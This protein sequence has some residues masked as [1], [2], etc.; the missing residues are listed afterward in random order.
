MTD[1]LMA[2]DEVVAAYYDER[3]RRYGDDVR[4]LDWGSRESQRLRFSV[5]SGVGP[6]AGSTLLDVG[7]GLG[8]L[9]GWVGEGVDYTGVDIAAAMVEAARSLRPARRFE[10]GHLLDPTFAPGPFD[11]VVA[12]GIFAKRSAEPQ[13]YFE[14]M[15]R[16]MWRRARR[17]V[18]FNVLSAWGPSPD[19][20][21]FQA[22]PLAALAFCRTLTP[23]VTLRH[24]YLP[25]DF[26]VYMYRD[27][28]GSVPS[29]AA[30]HTP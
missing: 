29:G 9:A 11:V 19:R 3:V 10:V 1:D 2:G 13:E 12:S 25:H 30:P 17:A 5:I 26:T 24:D 23:F 21:E 20:D 15:V 16:S 7:C 27:A 28:T 8:D 4:S 18:A 14:A 22:E 6:L